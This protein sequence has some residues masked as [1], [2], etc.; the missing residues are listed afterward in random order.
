MSLPRGQVR[1]LS[2]TNRVRGEVRSILRAPAP[3]HTKCPPDQPPSLAARNPPRANNDPRPEVCRHIFVGG[4]RADVAWWV[5]NGDS[6]DDG[7]EYVRCS[8]VCSV[9]CAAPL[10]PHTCRSAANSGARRPMPACRALPCCEPCAAATLADPRLHSRH[11]H[12]LGT[13][14][15]GARSIRRWGIRGVCHPSHMTSAIGSSAQ[16]KRSSRPTN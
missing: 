8:V 2:P 13:L 16:R 11:L 3:R 5:L 4:Y 9:G 15:L 1:P 7:R 14:P 6:E 10:Q 12:R